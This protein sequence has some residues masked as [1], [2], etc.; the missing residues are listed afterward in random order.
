VR[1]TKADAAGLIREMRRRLNLSQEKLAQRLKVSFP[2]INRWENRK[3]RP[4]TMAWHIIEQFLL[5]LGKDY[6]DLHARY[7]PS[8]EP[9]AGV[10]ATKRSAKRG[11]GTRKAKAENGASPP[12]ASGNG[13]MLDV[14]SMETMLWKAACSIRGE[15]DAPKFKDYILPL[16]FIKRLSDVFEDEVAR[17]TET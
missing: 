16:V 6:A 12:S 3:T 10:V 4:D 15:K 8:G 13:Q 17:L 9:Q 11:R 14:K 7:F 1:N 5:G 2:T